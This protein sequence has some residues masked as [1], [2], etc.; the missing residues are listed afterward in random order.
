MIDDWS[1]EKDYIYLRDDSMRP[2]VEEFARGMGVG[3]IGLCDNKH[4]K[5]G[6]LNNAMANTSSPLVVTV[7]A[8]MILRRE[9]LI[10]TVPYFYLPRLRQ[11]ETGAW[12]E[13][14]QEEMNPAYK[15]GF[16]QTPQ[17]FYNPDLYLCRK[18]HRFISPGPWG[19]GRFCHR[20]G[21][22]RL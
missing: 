10:K 12:L 15:I 16:I 17:S 2:E 19:R 9:F 3:Y 11:T 13:R 8:D 4:A 21:N 6:N 5:A 20:N 7:D 1:K 22:R 14:T 18:Q